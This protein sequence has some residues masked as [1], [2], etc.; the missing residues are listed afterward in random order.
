[1]QLPS[2]RYRA[3]ES[4]LIEA[5]GLHVTEHVVEVDAPAVS[6]RV[7]DVGSGDPMVF[8]HGAPN[9]AASWAPLAAQLTGNRCVL[10]DG[11]GAGLSSPVRKWDHYRAN[12]VAI[13][14]AVMSQLALT[15]P[16]LVGSSL[17]G[18]HAYSYAIGRRARIKGMVIVGCPAGPAVLPLPF[19][20]RLSALPLPGF[21]I[22][23]AFKPTVEGAK[24][25]HRDIGHGVSVDS[26]RIPEVVFEWYAELVGSTRT[27]R[28]MLPDVRA[29]TSFLGRKRTGR[30]ERDELE[31]LDLPVRYLWGDSDPLAKPEHGD[32]LAAL[33]PGA[34]I[35]HFE[36]FGHLPWLDDPQLIAASI[37][38][39]AKELE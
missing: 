17:G 7:L 28:N 20:E 6:I 14:D 33:T 10:I 24:K 16:V 27:V 29:F 5:Y 23:M 19:T 15:A 38:A 39:F 18:L 2:D 1:M 25:A 11:P 37:T 21:L 8:L 3:A 35:E 13:L 32:A 12:M 4:E 34:R 36:D 30:I 26:G 9:A 31:Q 22:D